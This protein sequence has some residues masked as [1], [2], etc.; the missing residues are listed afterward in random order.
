MDVD[1]I[2]VNTTNAP[3]HYRQTH[4]EEKKQELMTNNQCFVKFK[5]IALE[6]AAR[7]RQLVRTKAKEEP[8]PRPTQ[9]PK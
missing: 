4:S 5:D 2:E 9:S 6:T 3:H 1:S 8:V 7:N